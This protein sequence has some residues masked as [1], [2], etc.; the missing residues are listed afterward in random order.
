MSGP[1]PLWRRTAVLLG[2]ALLAGACGGCSVTGRVDV[3]DATTATV[4]VTIWSEVA[5]GAAACL[6]IPISQ[7]LTQTPLTNA[8]RPGQVGCHV[9]GDASSL[10]ADG[11]LGA[12]ILTGADDRLLL[13][14]PATYVEQIK[15]S[16]FGTSS[17]PNA[18][19][20]TVTF[21]GQAVAADP[22]ARIEGNSVRW[23]NWDAADAAGLKVEALVDSSTP[24]GIWPVAAGLAGL[25]LGAMAAGLA[26][27][28][29][30]GRRPPRPSPGA[31]AP[32]PGPVDP[33]DPVGPLD[34]AEGDGPLTEQPEDPSVWAPHRGQVSEP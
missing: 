23:T 5:E 10:L 18:L 1:S 24:P 34:A 26:F 4:D 28:L 20:L 22:S 11:G 6:P 15:L 29:S 25:A 33:V 19:D 27:V 17:E 3:R 30:S 8:Q 12:R 2:A 9:V 32:E 16:P 7:D 14:V 13:F 21:P 31:L